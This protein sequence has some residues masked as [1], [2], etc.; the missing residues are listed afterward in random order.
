MALNLEEALEQLGTLKGKVGSL[1][2]EVETLRGH[3]GT[4]EADLAKAKQRYK[5]AETERDDLRAKVP[6]NESVT[7][8][9]ADAERW[10]AYT[11]LGK[12]DEVKAALERVTTLET[13][14]AQAD[15]EATIR[16][17]GY[18]PKKLGR[19]IGS[20]ALKVEGEGDA[21]KVSVTIDDKDTLLDEWAE[22][23]GI[24]DLVNVARLDPSTRPAAMGQ[25]GD[26][27]NTPSPSTWSQAADTRFGVT[28]K[29]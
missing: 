28:K 2:S 13:E 10:Q 15:R 25:A 3:K 16:T 5:D 22:A 24:S 17:A 29:E 1:E 12:V 27:R 6:A 14:K 8:T 21:L 23:E 7:L 4:L 11:A 26:R 20:N 9:K 19:L 18:D